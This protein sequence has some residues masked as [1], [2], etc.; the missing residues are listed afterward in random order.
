[1]G[2]RLV[3]ATLTLLNPM[4]VGVP[5]VAQQQPLRSGDLARL[6]SVEDVQL[7][8]DG[9][10]IAYAVESRDRPGRAYSPMFIV[11]VATGVVSRLG[12][13]SGVAS[14]ARWSGDGRAIAYL[15]REG[16][17]SGLVVAQADGTNPVFLAP[18][19]GT[20]HGI[21]TPGEAVA[22]SPDGKRIAFVSAT[23]GPETR[24]AE[25]DPMVITRYRYKST[26][27]G[28]T[29]FDDNRRLHLFVVDIST[30][31]V[32]QLTDGI[33][34][35]HAIAWS[36]NGEE[37]LFI[38]NHAEPDP[39]RF[40]N[41]EAFAIRVSDGAIRQVTRS[42]STEERPVWSPDG[43]VIAFEGTKRAL[44]TSRPWPMQDT[45]IWLMNADGS[46]RHEL[47]AAIDNRQSSPRWAPDGS[48]VYFAVAEHGNMHLYRAP[49]GGGTPEPVINDPMS[50][51]G[52]WSVASGGTLAYALA[53]SR[54]LPQLY[55]KTPRA[56]R[57]LTRLNDSVLAGKAIAPV[58]S[59]AFL[60]FDG[61][62]VEAFLTKPVLT[63][64]NSRSPMI[65]MIH[66]GPH[67]AS[68]PTFDHKAQVYAARGWAT[69][70]VNYRGSTGYGQKFVD[71]TFRDQDGGEAQDVLDATD[72]ALRRNPWIDPQRLGIEGES[73]G[74]QLTNWL[75]TQTP[76]FKAAVSIAGIANLISFTYMAYYHDYLMGE[77]G[78]YPHQGDLMNVLWERSALK[79]VASV[80]TPTM[81]VHGENDNDVS[82][83]ENEQYY[84]ALKDV[85]VET[86]F[87]R[88]PR[89]GHGLSETGHQ[90][91]LIDRSIAWYERHFTEAAR[92]RP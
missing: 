49:A 26:S 51:V 69:L 18:A 57:Q 32:R 35:E 14:D 23:P 40:F 89:E 7:S 76:R 80:R 41:D 48:A 38:A 16:D 36:P 73:Y 78:G 39:D 2:I 8:P 85:G 62:P 81:L 21:R 79:H 70:M 13:E 43:K 42:E 75:T 24:D 22:W 88:Y 63:T 47:G 30:K 82:I 61:T 15:G 27:V 29:R 17:K 54:D 59:L 90:I 19:Q 77:F 28:S 87:V 56:T 71:G 72:V 46:D 5:L 58:E 67:G 33:Y 9:S 68:S 83:A 12:G 64:G 50:S 31:Q 20:N 4:L 74:G 11:T 44:Q 55:I 52:A 10:R 60:S 34:D 25:G 84:I 6:R 53:T 65:V 45:H 3:L 91:D 37:I 92:P 86:V 1:M 66:G